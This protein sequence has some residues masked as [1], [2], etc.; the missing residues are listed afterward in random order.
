MPASR[1]PAGHRAR[2]CRSYTRRESLS[3]GA[4]FCWNCRYDLGVARLLPQIPSRFARR[5][6]SNGGPDQ[7]LSRASSTTSRARCSISVIGSSFWRTIELIYSSKPVLLTFPIQNSPN[8]LQSVPNNAAF[9][10][11]I[12]LPGNWVL[13]S[14]NL[15]LPQ[16]VGISLQPNH[17]LRNCFPS[18]IVARMVKILV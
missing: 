11:S 14:V 3:Q 1:C 9:W 8:H 2:V 4:L 13:S 6:G 16:I 17:A 5:M 12:V 10:S 15:P 7:P 18:V